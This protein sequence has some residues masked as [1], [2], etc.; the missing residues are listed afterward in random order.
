MLSR[1]SGLLGCAAI[2]AAAGCA[3]NVRGVPTTSGVLGGPASGIVQSGWIRAG[4]IVYHVPHYMR[5]ISLTPLVSGKGLMFY[6]AGPVLTNPKAY[7]IFWGYRKYGDPDHLAKLLSAYFNVVGGSRHNDIYT[8]Y[9]QVIDHKRTHIANPQN[10]RGGVW[11]DEIHPVPES[12]TDAQV[13][14]EALKG[15][16]KLGYDPDGSYIVATP[17]ARFTKGFGTQWCAYHSATKYNGKRVSY[18][19]LPYIPD[20]GR[21]CGSDVITP[22]SDEPP[23]DEG[24]TIVEGH[25]YGESVTD[26][27]PGTGWYNPTYGEIGDVCAWYDILNVPFGDKSYTTQPMWSNDGE[28]CAQSPP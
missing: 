5:T 14:D 11:D 13:A 7:L 3:A 4:K 17:Q 16:A 27:I 19:N 20:A 18:T 9:Y 1:L 28:F 8:Q 25:E 2:L 21:P 24:V 15:V 26:P 6:Y 12:P 22:P 23:A 10:Q